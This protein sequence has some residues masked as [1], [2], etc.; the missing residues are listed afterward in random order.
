M[1]I[2]VENERSLVRDVN[3]GAILETDLQQLNRYRARVDSLK[4]KENKIDFLLEKINK[5]EETL[6]RMTNT[7]GYNNS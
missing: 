5:L 3:T 1:K 6:E 4:E 7:N 2:K